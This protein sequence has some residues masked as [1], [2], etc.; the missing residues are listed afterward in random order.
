MCVDVELPDGRGCDHLRA[1]REAHERA[2]A[3]HPGP[4]ALVALVRDPED[5]AE[6]Q[7]A[8]ISRVLR[9]PFDKEALVELLRRVGVLAGGVA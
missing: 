5:V 2:H 3:A 4:A 8:G 1:V 7:A 6:A 9:K